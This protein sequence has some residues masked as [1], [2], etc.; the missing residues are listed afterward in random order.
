MCVAWI[1]ERR[2]A[3]SDE[4]GARS[5]AATMLIF[6]GALLLIASGRAAA[7]RTDHELIAGE[8]AVG[9]KGESTPT[10]VVGFVGGFVHSDDVRHSEVQLARHLQTAYGERVEVEVFRNRQRE[11][12]HKAIVDWVSGLA[13]K[14]GTSSDQAKQPRIILFGHSWG[15]SAAVYL[16]RELDQD[17]IPVALTVQVDSVRKNGLDDSVIPTNVAAAVN[18]YQSKGVIHG[19]SYIVAADPSRTAILGN[20]HLDYRKQ[21]A[22]CRT[23]PWRDRFFFKG[24]TSIECDPRVWG[25]VESLIEARLPSNL[26]LP[27]TEI[28]AAPE[29]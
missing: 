29:R 13:S 28:A 22:E 16:A 2:N 10:L 23:Y 7:Q 18:F 19:R 17:G 3:H 25:Q 14:A 21:P 12:A 4:R 9:T 26:D 6:A 20:F 5:I 15:A 1:R 24:H 8:P 11:R 27:H